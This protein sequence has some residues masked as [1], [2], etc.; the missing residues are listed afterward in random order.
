M[1]IKKVDNYRIRLNEILG[2]SGTTHMGYNNLNKDEVVIKIIPRSES[3]Y[4][5]L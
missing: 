4:Q 3:T 1:S 2:P 5:H